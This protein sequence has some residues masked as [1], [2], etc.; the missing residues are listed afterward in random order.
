LHYYLYILLGVTFF[1]ATVP[2]TKIALTSFSS[3]EIS[4]VRLVV[5]GLFALAYLAVK[6]CI[7]HIKLHFRQGALIA[8]GIGSFPFF[9]CNAMEGLPGTFGSVALG[10]LP[11][12]TGLL[13]IFLFKEK[14]GARYYL[15]SVLGSAIV[16]LYSLEPQF[17]SYHHLGM[18]SAA[19]L[20]V[21]TGYAHGSNLAKKTSGPIAI[22]IGLTIFLPVAIALSLIHLDM[23]VL[24]KLTHV[25]EH[26]V[27]ALL[28]LAAFS[29]YLG[30][31][32]FY[33]GLSRTGTAKGIQVQLLQP[34]IGLG[35]SVFLLG[36]STSRTDYLALGAVLFCV[37]MANKTKKS[38][39]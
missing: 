18:L 10:I 28:Y 14:A 34:F 8:I 27:Q 38:L 17:E 39:K 22:S 36:E 7:P 31:F 20:F 35:M 5:G 30:F 13:S 25:K 33:A 15:F 2:V 6:N 37:S 29:Q 19:I 16:V 32:P 23:S 12:I 11:L 1:A 3:L 26:S 9:L 21:S 24:M 4:L